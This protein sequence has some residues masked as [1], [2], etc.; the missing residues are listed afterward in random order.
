V[1]AGAV[2]AEIGTLRP[3][4]RTTRI[5]AID[6]HGG[7]GKSTLARAI[8]S[9]IAAVTIV[10]MDAF[11]RPRRPGWEWERLKHGV[12]G[13]LDRDETGRYQRHDWE[14]DA[15]AEW[16]SVPPGGIVV[17]EGVSAMKHELGAYWD[18]AV[19]VECPAATR[20]ARGIARDGEPMRRQWIDAW[21]PWEDAYVR[22]E[23]PHE[24]ANL[25]VDGAS[26]HGGPPRFRA[27]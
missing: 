8:A 17:V 1:S 15:L 23:R 5:V 16:H 20:L 3:R 6:G 18:L 22:D 11:A 19:W 4:E 26:P 14:R 25:I 12:L 2:I 21:M 9:A 7:A 27:R 24:R 10:P 13:P